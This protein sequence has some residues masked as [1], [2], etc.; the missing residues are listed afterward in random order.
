[1]C[2]SSSRQTLDKPVRYRRVATYLFFMHSLKI[3]VIDRCWTLQNSPKTWRTRHSVRL[4]WRR[5]RDRRVKTTATLQY[6]TKV[7]IFK[8]WWKTQSHHALLSA[9]KAHLWLVS[10]YNVT[11]G[12]F[13]HFKLLAWHKFANDAVQDACKHALFFCS[14]S[15]ISWCVIYVAYN[16]AASF[17]W[18]IYC[19]TLLQSAATLFLDQSIV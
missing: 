13:E 3:H 11:V 8:I 14:Y 5:Q 2:N 9:L 10:T 1:M 6:R 19:K 4:V 15:V 7:S 18:H 16:V 12:V 17:V